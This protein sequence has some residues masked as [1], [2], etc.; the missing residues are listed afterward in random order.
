VEYPDSLRN[1][2]LYD[3]PYN[4]EAWQIS[5]D[6]VNA[7]ISSRNGRTATDPRATVMSFR[8]PLPDRDIDNCPTIT[9][10]DQSD[11]NGDGF[12]DACVS[13]TVFIPST[14]D[15]GANPII[16]SGTLINSGF[17]LAPMRRLG[18]M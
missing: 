15:I 18:P 17:R 13:P 12:G 4:A 8:A 6:V 3:A 2:I 9:N 11:A 10:P 14:A 7:A 5:N 16:G 1:L